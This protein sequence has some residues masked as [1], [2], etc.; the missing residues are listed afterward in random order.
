MPVLFADD[1][2]CRTCPPRNK[3]L[4]NG[5][6]IPAKCAGGRNVEFPYVA[7]RDAA[8]P[9][10]RDVDDRAQQQEQDDGEC[11]ASH[12]TIVLISRRV[13]QMGGR[14]RFGCA[15]RYR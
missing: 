7:L 3:Y 5:G 15:L 9:R 13:E 4:N 11:P 14:D 1:D 8:L 6:V 12:A 10:H 2:P